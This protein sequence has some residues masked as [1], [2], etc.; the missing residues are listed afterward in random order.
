M[1]EGEVD[2]IL[3]SVQTAEMPTY[4][5]NVRSADRISGSPALYTIAVPQS[6]MPSG[7]YKCTVTTYKG[8]AEALQLEA[9]VLDRVAATNQGPWVT[10]AFSSGGTGKLTGTCF[11]SCIPPQLSL[12]WVDNAGLN[13]SGVTSEHQLVLLFESL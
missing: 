12:R 4:L 13:T 3:R 6:F 8:T 11:F 7:P 1:S 2:F 5:L 10:V 9:R